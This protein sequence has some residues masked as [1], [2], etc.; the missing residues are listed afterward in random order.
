L[1]AAGRASGERVWCFPMDGDFDRELETPV[2]DILQCT[3]RGSGDHILAAR[4]LNR[5]VEPQIPW[6]HIDLSASERK[7]GLA[8]IP[9]DMTG[10]G[11]RYGYQ[12][13][14]DGSLLN[15]LREAS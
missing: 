1:Q 9:T 4:F 13:L 12:L 14:S 8:H 3:V 6:V 11:V 2:A 7:G 10:F 5:F 15:G